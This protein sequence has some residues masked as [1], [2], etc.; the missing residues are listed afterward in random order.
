MSKKIFC[1]RCEAWFDKKHKCF[2]Y[3]KTKKESDP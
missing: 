3:T 1:E 2:E